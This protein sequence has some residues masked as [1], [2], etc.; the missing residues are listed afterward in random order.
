MN[1]KIEDS[2]II[3]RDINA[4]FDFISNLENDRYW[5]KEINSTMMK[6]KPQVNTEAT[7]D[8]FLSKRKPNHLS[9]L[10]CKVY[11][12]NIQIVYETI[13]GSNY[14][15]RSNRQVA[16]VLQNQTKLTYTVEFDKNIVKYGTGFALPEFIIHFVAR[17][18]M[19]KYLARLKQVLERNDTKV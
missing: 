8:S 14:F 2:I 1:I 13:P 3:S 11:Q 16:P 12:E 4:V 6:G 18:D 19:K 9:N 10:I 17:R 15:L 5:R 7:E